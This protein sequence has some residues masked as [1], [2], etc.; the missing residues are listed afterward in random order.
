MALSTRA[1]PS[2]LLKGERLTRCGARKGVAAGLVRRKGLRLIIGS[3]WGRSGAV[4]RLLRAAVE[5]LPELR[6][7]FLVFVR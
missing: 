7:V 1:A 2:V 5:V 6:I 4:W 3:A